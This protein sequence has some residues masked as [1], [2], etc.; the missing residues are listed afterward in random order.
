MNR[1][2]AIGLL[3]CAL[4]LGLMGCQR[5]GVQPPTAPP[6]AKGG[7][8]IRIAMIAKSSTNPVFLSARAG[9]EADAP[10]FKTAAGR[11]GRKLAVRVLD[12][13]TSEPFSSS[14]DNS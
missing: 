5:G 11:V 8:T 2:T 6:T 9:A 13:L 12:G 14:D 1:L 4:L 10:R 3:S 7:K